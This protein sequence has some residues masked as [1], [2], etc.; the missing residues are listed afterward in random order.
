[1]VGGLP[2][3]E[4]ILLVSILTMSQVPVTNPSTTAAVQ[5]YV[6]DYKSDRG[7]EGSSMVSGLSHTL[8]GLEKGTNYTLSVAGVNEAGVGKARLTDSVQTAVDGEHWFDND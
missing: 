1:M 5:F 6:I 3:V 8:G 4:Q 2:S 7:N